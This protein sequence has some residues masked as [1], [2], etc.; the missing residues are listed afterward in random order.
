MC[1]YVVVAVNLFVV[2]FSP[3]KVQPGVVVGLAVF[4]NIWQ[5][6]KSDPDFCLPLVDFVDGIRR[7][8]AP[9]TY[10][11]DVFFGE[12]I[13]NV[14]DVEVLFDRGPKE[15]KAGVA[16]EFF[17]LETEI[18]ARLVRFGFRNCFRLILAT[19]KSTPS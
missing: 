19:P 6:G 15:L 10:R 14:T 3:A 12:M 5:S 11:F 17:N 8:V 18:R 1:E 16:S 7:F 13:E 4:N 2:L 9:P